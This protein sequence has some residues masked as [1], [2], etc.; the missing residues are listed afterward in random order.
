M[1]KLHLKLNLCVMRSIDRIVFACNLYISFK[2]NSS[3]VFIDRNREFA[4]IKRHIHRFS[5][6]YI[7]GY[8]NFVFY[9]IK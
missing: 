8:N 3:C 4:I 2:P 6:K 1:Y 5:R 9:K 7:T